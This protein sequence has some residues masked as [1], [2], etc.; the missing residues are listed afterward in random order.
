MPLHWKIDECSVYFDR[1][2]LRGWCHHSPSAIVGVEAW[3]GTPPH[4]VRLT[5]YGLP[6]PDVAAAI[7]PGAQACRLDE[8]VVVPEEYLGRDFILRLSLAD[9]S[10]LSTDSA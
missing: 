7:D 3:F 2:H 5:S 4:V 1:L 6:S 8:W 9:G 10:T